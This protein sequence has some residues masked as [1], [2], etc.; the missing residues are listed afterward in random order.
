M[1][2]N[3]INSREFIFDNQKEQKTE[4]R[5]NSRSQLRNFLCEDLRLGNYIQNRYLVSERKLQNMS[6]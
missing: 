3:K 1:K 2:E 4:R 6:L 5:K